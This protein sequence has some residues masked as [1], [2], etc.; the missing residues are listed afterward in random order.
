MAV[1]VGNLRHVQGGDTRSRPRRVQRPL[2]WDA[3]AR[4]P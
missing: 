3:A 2:T 1:Q 4:H